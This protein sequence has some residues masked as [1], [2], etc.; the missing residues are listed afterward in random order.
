M[1]FY[2]TIQSV[3]VEKSIIDKAYRFAHDVIDTTNYSDTK[4]Y[5][6]SKILQDHLTSKIGEEAAKA[7]L[8]NFAAVSGPDYTIYQGKQKSWADDL[9]VGNMGIA[10]KTQKRS[11][12]N[13]FGLSWTFQASP[14]RMDTILARPAA[15]VIFVEYNDL[16][17]NV[18]NVY[19][20][21]QIRELTM[22]EPMLSK[23][24]G[25]KKVVYAHTLPLQ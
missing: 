11:A 18:C 10:V 12:A 24:K 16:L 17:G 3:T 14:T 1:R 19:P 5:S 2:S 25:L 22:G 7:V 21:F 4:Q 20:P 8:K 13:H 23:L 9:Y 15:W 6:R